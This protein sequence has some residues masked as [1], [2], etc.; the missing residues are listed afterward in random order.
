MSFACQINLLS[1]SAFIVNQL[2]SRVNIYVATFPFLFLLYSGLLAHTFYAPL[3]D[4]EK[5]YGLHND[6]GDPG[7]R[8]GNKKKIQGSVCRKEYIDNCDM[9]E[10]IKLKEDCNFILNTVF[11][12]ENKKYINK[13]EKEYNVWEKKCQDYEVHQKMCFLECYSNLLH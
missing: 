6:G 3:P 2:F 9:N 10:R 4:K 1:L 5:A 11:N 13:L 7:C 8:I 12:T